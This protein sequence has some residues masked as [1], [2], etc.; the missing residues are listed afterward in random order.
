VHDLL[1]R[2]PMISALRDRWGTAIETGGVV[3]RAAVGGRVFNDPE[4]LAWLEQQVH[5]LVQAEIADWFSGL[6]EDCEVAVVEVPLLFEGEMSD[7]FDVTVAVVADETV[8]NERA[9]A[10]GQ[11]GLEGRESRQLSQDEKAAKADRVIRNDGTTAELEAR[12]REML[13]QL[14]AA[15]PTDGRH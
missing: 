11:V 1:D 6:P 13:T 12:L 2:E 4:E 15:M 7:R 9:E 14:G 8:R 10:R 3:D 5:P